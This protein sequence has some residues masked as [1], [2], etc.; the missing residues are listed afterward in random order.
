V[1][2][3]LVEAFLHREKTD[4]KRVVKESIVT[5][6]VAGLLLALGTVLEAHFMEGFPSAGKPSS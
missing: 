4:G 6:F 3:R 5:L 2:K 1:S